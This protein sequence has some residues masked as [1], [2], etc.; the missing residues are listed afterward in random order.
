MKD[1]F[2]NIDDTCRRYLRR[3]L[4]LQAL[5]IFLTGPCDLDHLFLFKISFPGFL[6]YWLICFAIVWYWSGQPKSMERIL[7]K[8]GSCL[9]IALT[10]VIASIDLIL[11]H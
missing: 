6:L 4:Y 8:W 2:R 1:F 9:V 10:I 5:V 3:N 11:K 7:I